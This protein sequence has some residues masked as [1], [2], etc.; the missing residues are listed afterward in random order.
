MMVKT[1]ANGNVLSYNCSG[2]VQGRHSGC[3][4]SIHGHY[5]YMNLFEGNVLQFLKYADWW[6][7]T[8]PLTTCF[9]NRVTKGI[10][11]ADAS[12]RATIIGNT[13]RSVSVARGCREALVGVTRKGGKVSW[14]KLPQDTQLPASL[15]LDGPPA[16]WGDRPW[17]A[18]GAD[19]DKGKPGS[20]TPLPAQ[21]RYRNLHRGK[22]ASRK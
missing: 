20:W 18:I 10:S 9:R 15:Y 12:H 1:G 22:T 6:G 21:D 4:V 19:V 11:V 17:P 2:G 16:F 14:G 3:D 8:G 5:S 13:T 7:P